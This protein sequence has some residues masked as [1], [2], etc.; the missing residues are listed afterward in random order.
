MSG[1]QRHVEVSG[2]MSGIQRHTLK[3]VVICEGFRDTR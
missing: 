1:V 3:Y 2:H